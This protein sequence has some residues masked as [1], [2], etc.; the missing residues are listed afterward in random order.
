VNE[1]QTVLWVA[2]KMQSLGSVGAE[3][4]RVVSWVTGVL[5]VIGVAPLISSF[6]GIDAET[7]IAAVTSNPGAEG[8]ARSLAE[9]RLAEAR[10]ARSAEPPLPRYR[11]EQEAGGDAEPTTAPP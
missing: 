7:F 5:S 8:A 9:A 3:V 11:A 6:A 1:N 10:R 2:L 4:A